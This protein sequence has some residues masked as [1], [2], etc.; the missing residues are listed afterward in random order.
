MIVLLDTLLNFKYI[1]IKYIGITRPMAAKR[2]PGLCS[3]WSSTNSLYNPQ[4]YMLALQQIPCN[5]KVYYVTLK[6][7][8]SKVILN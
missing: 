8:N 3:L 7:R 4:K 5:I 1:E 6:Y 2:P